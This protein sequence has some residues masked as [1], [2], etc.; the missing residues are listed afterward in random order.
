MGHAHESLGRYQM[1]WSTIQLLSVADVV[2]G[3][4]PPSKTYNESAEGLPFFQG[5]AEFGTEY[6]TIKKWCTAP[7]RTADKGDILLS[8]RAPVGPTN[9]AP[10]HCCIGRGLVAIRA[11]PRLIE[12]SFIRYFF[13]YI[14]PVLS[15]RGQG[16]T[17][18]AINRR[19]IE[20]LRVPLPPLSEQRQIVK[21][22]DQAD[23]LRRTRTDTDSKAQHILP[24]LFTNMFGDPA[25]NPKNWPRLR[26]DKICQVI[27]G[28]TPR[29]DRAEY[30]GGDIAWVTPK[31]LSALDD[32]ILE[33]TERTLSR[34]GLASCSTTVMQS[35][36]VLLSSRA[37]IGLVVVSGVPVCTNQGLKS[38]VCGPMIDPWYLF[39]WCK[40]R[41]KYLQSLGYGATFKEV[42]KRT[43]EAIEIPVPPL[44]LQQRFGQSLRQVR[45]VRQ[46][47]RKSNHGIN[48][49]FEGLLHRAFSGG[50][51]AKW[52]DARIEML[53]RE[54]EEQAESIRSACSQATRVAS[55]GCAKTTASC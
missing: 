6:P 36:A 30:W 18:T 29:T 27:S 37:P 10:T 41:T 4:S 14:E 25:T 46:M 54:G 51:T 42:S 53:L 52:R 50:L 17:F 45:N 48:D 55:W 49:L 38:F 20:Q 11:K 3:Q 44:P 22:L 12:Q 39:A 23:I 1:N 26:L 32:W 9:I 21:I 40:I 28:A 16:S 7:S 8:V 19:V 34:E 31:D 2:M 35:G 15:R 24:A 47:A 5:K 13:K 43:I 33:R